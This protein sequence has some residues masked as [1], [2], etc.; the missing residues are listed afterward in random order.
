[1]QGSN[2]T[3]GVQAIE[4]EIV[5]HEP[6]TKGSYTANFFDLFRTPYIRRVT[7]VMSLAWFALGTLYF[8]LSLHMPQFDANI[9]VI[10]FLSGL[11]SSTSTQEEFLSSHAT[12]SLNVFMVHLQESPITVTCAFL[13]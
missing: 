3:T 7:I 4:K 12:K 10:F 2:T 5:I 11:V 6:N 13:I 9:Y 1:M 8:G